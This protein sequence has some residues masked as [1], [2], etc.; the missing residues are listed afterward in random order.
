MD[1]QRWI[2][3]SGWVGNVSTS[4]LI[5]FVNKLLMRTEGGYSFRFATTLTAMHFLFCTFSVWVTQGLGLVKRTSI[6]KRDVLLFALVADISILALNLSLMINTVS[7]YQIAKL[8]IIPF[9]CFVEWFYM[10]RT[11]TREVA[12]TILVVI[13]GVAIVTVEDLRL[14]ISVTGACIAGVSVVSSGLQ[15]IFVRSLQQKHGLSS[16]ELLSNTAPAQAWTLLVVGP[17]VDKVVSGG[18][19]FHYTLTHGALVWLI[20]SCILAVLVNITQFMCLGRFSAVSFQ[21]LGHSK[22]VMVLLGGW[23]FLGD[24]LS[25]RKLLGM[26]LAVAGM[27]WYGKASAAA[28]VP[29]SKRAVSPAPLGLGGDAEGAGG[30]LLGRARSVSGDGRITVGPVA[31][32]MRDVV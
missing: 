16:H 13:I 11:F 24:E 28:P 32:K 26:T 23:L 30:P 4:V 17:F 12:T 7:F 21:V 18:W 5:V 29:A 25:P 27:V 1:P 2:D 6:P 3:L 10:G 19:V 8:L 15:Q 20:G 9:V 31:G 14:K 22:T